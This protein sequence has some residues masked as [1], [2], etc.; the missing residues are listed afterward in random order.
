ML[1]KSL[2]FLFV[3]LLILIGVYYYFELGKQSSEKTIKNICEGLSIDY[4]YNTDGCEYGTEYD[5]AFGDIIYTHCEQ[6]PQEVIDQSIKDK[7]LCEE[8]GGFWSPPENGYQKYWSG[9]PA[10]KCSDDDLNIRFIPHKGCLELA[11]F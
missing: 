6:V 10:C 1:R 7:K 11:N 8:T 9:W 3:I 5:D 4:C 2:I